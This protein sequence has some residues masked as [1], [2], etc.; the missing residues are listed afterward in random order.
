MTRKTLIWRG[1]DNRSWSKSLQQSCSRQTASNFSSFWDVGL[2]YVRE[3]RSNVCTIEQILFKYSRV[4]WP[5]C[6]EGMSGIEGALQMHSEI[7]DMSLCQNK[8]PMLLLESVWGKSKVGT[9]RTLQSKTKFNMICHSNLEE[10]S[11][12][13]LKLW[14]P[15]PPKDSFVANQFQVFHQRQ[16]M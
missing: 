11:S 10:K 12:G 2:V 1:A 16:T 4:R 3:H 8:L 9:V 14:V 15:V 6:Q 13:Y 5:Q 7:S